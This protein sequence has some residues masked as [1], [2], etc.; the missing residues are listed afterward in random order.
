MTN[1]AQKNLN[2][3][4]LEKLTNEKQ[5]IKFNKLYYD[6]SQET[7]H[8]MKIQFFLENSQ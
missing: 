7:N 2:I 1:Q 6:K 4:H 8:K 5:H 3:Y